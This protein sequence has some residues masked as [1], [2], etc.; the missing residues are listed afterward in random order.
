VSD[1]E[2]L[3]GLKLHRYMI[4]PKDLLN[5]TMNALNCE[6]YNFAPSGMGNITSAVNAPVWISNPHFCNADPSLIEAIGGMNPNPEIHLTY[7]DI[8]PQTG[9]IGRGYK[10]VQVNWE[11]KAYNMAAANEDLVTN[12]EQVCGQIQT[13]LNFLND[14]AENTTVPTI[15]CDL[16]VAL[17]ALTSLATP[18]N[19]NYN[20]KNDTLYFP[21]YYCREANQ[22][23]AADAH[24][25]QTQLYDTEDMTNET[26]KWCFIIAAALS[27]TLVLQI[28]MRRQAARD[29]K[30]YKERFE[31]MHASQ[32]KGRT[33]NPALA[34]LLSSTGMNNN[35]S[36]APA[37]TSF[38]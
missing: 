20:G 26:Q 18:S 4:Q 25:L 2:D 34:P 8:E 17:N 12:T 13:A 38:T 24:D 6:Y 3:Y 37:S 11:M 35:N 19:W 31:M 9:Q 30:A 32:S 14:T 1:N 28:I 29:L 23:S 21:S 16:T 10:T 5:C 27:F 33:M 15:D 36:D 7:V 22:L